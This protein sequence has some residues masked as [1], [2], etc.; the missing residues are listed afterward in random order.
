MKVSFRDL[1]KKDGSSLLCSFLVQFLSLG[2]KNRKKP[3]PKKFLRFREMGLCDSNTEKFLIFQE[4]ETL[5]KLLIFQEI[6]SQALKNKKIHP[7]KNSLYTTKWNFLAL[8]LKKFKKQ[9]PHK[10]FTILQEMKTSKKLV[11][12]Q[13]NAF[14]IFPETETQNILYI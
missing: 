9:K 13:K 4:M 12:S 6:I 3:L 7:E 8:I 1:R 10:K 11:F 2:L 5:K 14:H